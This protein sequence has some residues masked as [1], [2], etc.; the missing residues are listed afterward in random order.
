MRPWILEL[1]ICLGL[2]VLAFVMFS[3]GK[4]WLRRLGGWVLMSSTGLAL[5]FWTRNGLA[6]L[7]GVVVWFALPVGQAVWMSRRLKFAAHRQLET[8]H[9]DSHEIPEMDVL[10]SE[11]RRLDFK[12]EGDFWLKPAIVEQGYRLLVHEKENVYAAIALIR[13]GGAALVYA[14]FL[15]PDEN[16]V[17]WQTWDYPLA[18]GLKMPPHVVVYRCLDSATLP[19]LYEQH[20]Q[21]ISINEVQKSAA[22]KPTQEFFNA[23]FDSLIQYNLTAGM[24]ISSSRKTDEIHY[25]WRGTAFVSWQVFREVVMG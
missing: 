23:F 7:L 15:T 4:P 25:T 22:L 14:M 10:T 20:R 9:F 18:Y 5:W 3:S 19:E 12:W 21:F 11:L 13:Y 8:G 1:G 6:A 16:S 2:V 17:I 24:L